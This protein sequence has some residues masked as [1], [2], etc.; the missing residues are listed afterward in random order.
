MVSIYS[1]FSI[2][3]YFVTINCILVLVLNGYAYGFWN[4]FYFCDI[5]LFLTALTFWIPD[6]YRSILSSLS[7]LFALLS[8]LVWSIDL[9]T[10]YFDVSLFGMAY[11]MYNPSYHIGMRF[12]STFHLWLWI[13]HLYLLKKYKY[14]PTAFNYWL[15]IIFFLYFLFEYLTPKQPKNINSYEIYYY[16][17]ILVII[18]YCLHRLFFLIF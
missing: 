3:K 12:L 17:Y 16:K 5:S 2:L 11:Y 6:K 13:V 7:A 9:I 15:K 1:T 10:L 14:N 4:L 8:S 18:T